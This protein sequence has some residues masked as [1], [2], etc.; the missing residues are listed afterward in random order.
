MQSNRLEALETLTRN[1]SFH[2]IS[3]IMWYQR[4]HRAPRV[5]GESHNLA[6]P[7]EQTPM[8]RWLEEQHAPS[9][10]EHHAH[11]IWYVCTP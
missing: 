3:V 1:I 6:S 2:A 4:R 9:D 8:E 7:M 10:V 11:D 5:A